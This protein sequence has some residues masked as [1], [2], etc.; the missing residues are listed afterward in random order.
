MYKPMNRYMAGIAVLCLWLIS[1]SFAQDEE[2]VVDE[3]SVDCVNLRTVRRTEVIDDRNILFHMRGGDVYHNVLPRDCH[4]LKREDRFGY[5]TNMGRLC[6]LDTIRVL[7]NDG[8]GMREGAACGLGLFHKI[9]KETAEAF[10]ESFDKMPEAEPLPM[11]EPGE[12]DDE[13]DDEDDP[14]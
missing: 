10:R 13:K 2:P 3:N 14:R 9:D 11:P 5:Q 8:M 12:V 7:Y 1:P 6:R 4:G